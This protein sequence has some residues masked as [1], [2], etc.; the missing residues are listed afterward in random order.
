MQTS[1]PVALEAEGT[2]AEAMVEGCSITATSTAGPRF[3][4]WLQWTPMMR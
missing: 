4:L 3:T 1:L 2:Q